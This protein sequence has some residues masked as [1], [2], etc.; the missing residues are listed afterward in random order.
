MNVKTI[1]K[2]VSCLTGLFLLGSVCGFAMSGRV[3]TAR[4][5]AA[6]SGGGQWIERW[7]DRRM[8]GDF[9]TI[10]ATPEQQAELRASYDDLRAEL[11]AIRKESAM[12]V[13]A[14]ITR[15]RQGMWSK[16]TPEQRKALWQS[17]QERRTR[18]W[19]DRRETPQN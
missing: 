11:E 17:N 7:L 12:K 13:T 8:A 1:V 10:E 16:L 19:D 3:A 6:F 18:Y 4:G 14:A 15:H 5:P 2:I 9:A